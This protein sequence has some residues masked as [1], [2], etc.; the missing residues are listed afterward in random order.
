MNDCMLGNILVV[1]QLLLVVILSRTALH[2]SISTARGTLTSTIIDIYAAVIM[3]TEPAYKT[4]LR[5]TAVASALTNQSS[6]KS[7]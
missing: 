2:Y 4:I 3:L 5:S 7:E 6:S 1:F